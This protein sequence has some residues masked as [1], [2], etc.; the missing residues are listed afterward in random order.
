MGIVASHTLS[1]HGCA[2]LRALW[3]WVPRRHAL[4]LRGGVWR[5]CVRR[6]ARVRAACGAHEAA[7]QVAVGRE[8]VGPLPEEVGGAARL[9]EGEV[10]IEDAR[11]A[12]GRAA[13]ARKLEPA[14]RRGARIAH[15]AW[16]S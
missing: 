3:A 4:S 11:E 14:T 1:G 16:V 2:V 10:A 15:G 7:A 5:R 13:R 8:A 9:S 12:R 6:V